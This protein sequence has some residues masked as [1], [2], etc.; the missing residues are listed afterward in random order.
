MKTD[1]GRYL[2]QNHPRWLVAGGCLIV[3]VYAAFVLLS[4]ALMVLGVM[5]LW[6]A[7]A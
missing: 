7:V 5:W 1:L 6:R 3:I 2:E 4:L